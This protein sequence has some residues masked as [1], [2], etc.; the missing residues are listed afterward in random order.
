MQTLAKAQQ[1][2]RAKECKGK[3]S[4]GKS[5]R[6]H[7]MNGAGHLHSPAYSLRDVV[8]C[9]AHLSRRR[10]ERR[11]EC[12]RGQQNLRSPRTGRFVHAGHLHSYHHWWAK[13]GRLSTTIMSTRTLSSTLPF[14]PIPVTAGAWQLPPSL[15]VCTTP[16]PK[17]QL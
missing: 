11:D 13:L 14:T 15:E 4:Q 5:S 6:S 8:F 12:T 2:D 3:S 16:G 10:H 17:E 1:R 7:L 9:S